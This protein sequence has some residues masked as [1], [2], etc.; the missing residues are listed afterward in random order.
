MDFKDYQKKAR[1]TA[2]YPNVGK[3]FVYPALGLGGET[4]EVLEKIKKIIRDNNGKITP[5]IKEDLKKEMGDVLWYLS[6]LASEIGL[7]LDEVAE[8]N[9]R[10]LYS[11]KERGKIHGSGDDR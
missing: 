10:K 7:S 9:I 1:K 11:R 3:N 4:G 6:N 8:E 2:I 5:K